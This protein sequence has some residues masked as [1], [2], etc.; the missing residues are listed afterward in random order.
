MFDGAFAD[1]GGEDLDRHAVRPIIDGL[2]QHHGDRVR[3]FTRGTGGHPDAQGRI[4]LPRR[5]QCGDDIAG[6]DLE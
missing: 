4:W 6:Q 5:Q 2:N 1:I 3:F